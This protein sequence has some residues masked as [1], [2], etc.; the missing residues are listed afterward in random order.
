M[1]S[2]KVFYCSLVDRQVDGG[3]LELV[4]HKNI[5]I[6]YITL[7]LC[8]MTKAYVSLERDVVLSECMV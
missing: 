3:R 4:R 2:L 7:L 5:K 6:S 8:V 1:S